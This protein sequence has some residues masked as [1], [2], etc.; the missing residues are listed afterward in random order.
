VNEKQIDFHK[1]GRYT[2]NPSVPTPL[3]NLETRPE[4]MDD[5]MNEPLKIRNRIMS[6]KLSVNEEE[7][8]EVKRKNTEMAFEEVNNPRKFSVI[9][10]LSNVSNVPLSNL[11]EGRL[12][13]DTEKL[14]CE[15]EKQEF[16]EVF[17]ENEQF[18]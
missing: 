9:S 7:I 5:E 1:L 13:F 17:S 8:L 4:S 10:N 14:Y 6:E 15:E 18:L 16:M 11:S 2:K 12:V 3:I